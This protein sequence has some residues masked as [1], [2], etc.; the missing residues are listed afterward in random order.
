MVGSIALHGALGVWFIQ[1]KA[2]LRAEP[3]LA[4]ETTLRGTTFEMDL[5]SM[6]E[7]DPPA[8]LAPAPAA[9]ASAVPA[10]SAA[11][12]AETSSVQPAIE[13]HPEPTEK[14]RPAVAA[15]KPK[16]P[17]PPSPPKRSPSSLAADTQPKP[18]SAGRAEVGGS[19]YGAEGAAAGR[20]SLLRSFIKIL[21][22]AAKLLPG[23]LDADLGSQAKVL[24]ELR[25]S[26]EGE[27][28]SI[29][30]LKGDKSQLVAQ[31]IRRS[32]VF[33]RSGRFVGAAGM[34]NTLLVS[35]RGTISMKP[36]N[37]DPDAAGKVIALGQRT[38]PAHPAAPPTGAY[39]TFGSGRHV[40]LEVEPLPVPE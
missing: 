24:A 3:S 10:A 31:S 21:P 32:Q 36:S 38:D 2:R 27:L 5:G 37:E 6:R 13:P 14:P 19:S 11:E 35:V 30:I 9:P 20:L 26:G 33:L 23:W 29:E 4:S 22:L 16:Q 28:I 40:E 18:P 12:P 15:A 25:V 17:S 8:A 1:Q 7:S 39:F 34:V